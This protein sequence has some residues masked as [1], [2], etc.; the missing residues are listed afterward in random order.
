[1]IFYMC[2]FVGTNLREP[3]RLRTET[4]SSISGDERAIN[5]SRNDPSL[6][7]AENKGV[8]KKADGD[9]GSGTN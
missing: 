3:S 2:P 9:I 6:V 1:M 5:G 7:P 8:E 4:L